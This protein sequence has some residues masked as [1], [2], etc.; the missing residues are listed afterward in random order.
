MGYQIRA[1]R[2]SPNV[3]LSVIVSPTAPAAAS[4][5]VAIRD[6]TSP[7]TPLPLYLD[8]AD[9]TFKTV[10]WATRQAAMTALGG[11]EFALDGGL[12][13]AGF[14]NLPPT[15]I[16]LAAVY[17]VTVG[18]RT[19]TDIDHLELEQDSTQAEFGFARLDNNN[20][21]VTISGKRRG[22]SVPLLTAAISFFNSDG[23]L[24][25]SSAGPGAPDAQGAIRFQ[26]ANTLIAQASYATATVTD[27]IGTIVT[28]RHVPFTA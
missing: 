2:R 22:E 21:E 17:G 14:T 9:L 24:R 26:F 6:E 27:A 11:N 20:V 5:V 19:L 4:A 13:V 10:G 28:T 7:Q 15:T 25:F 16:S 1:D 23:T 18:G 12:N 8:F 3:A